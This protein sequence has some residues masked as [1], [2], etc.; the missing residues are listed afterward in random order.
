MQQLLWAQKEVRGVCSWQVMEEGVRREVRGVWVTRARHALT[1]LEMQ[2]PH[3]KCEQIL[4]SGRR[5]AAPGPPGE[6]PAHTLLS[7][8]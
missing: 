7:T 3:R 6:S 2:G 1:S 8:L 4:G 5:L